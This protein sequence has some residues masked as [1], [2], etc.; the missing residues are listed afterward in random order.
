[1]DTPLKE[2]LLGLISIGYPKS[3]VTMQVVSQTSIVKNDGGEEGVD[4]NVGTWFF[5]GKV[6]DLIFCGMHRD[7]YHAV[8]MTALNNAATEL[9][10]MR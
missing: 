3:L 6:Q 8:D 7:L 10:M 9:T 1:L 5:W 4:A 2:G